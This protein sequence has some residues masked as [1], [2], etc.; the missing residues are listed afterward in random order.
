MT[1]ELKAILLVFLTLIIYAISILVTDGSLIFPFLLNEAIFAALILQ[2]CIWERHLK[3][4]L[5]FPIGIAL[6]SIASSPFLWEI[7]LPIES[8]G[9]FYESP[10]LDIFK[11]LFLMTM[12]FSGVAMVRQQEKW[13][14]RTLGIFGLGLFSI[15]YTIDNL[16]YELAGSIFIAASV[17]IE[18]TYKPFN[19]LWLLL[20]GLEVT[21]V[22][23]VLLA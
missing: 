16:W 15:G 8:L 23:T 14:M 5:L 2:F 3:L 11:L 12:V 10:A 4:K 13:Q 20:A 1:R 7:V 18:P 21:E 6:L 22:V 19:T 17:M 9:P